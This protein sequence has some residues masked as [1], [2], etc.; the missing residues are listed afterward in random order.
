MENL[1]EYIKYIKDNI[2]SLEDSEKRM[3]NEYIFDLSSKNNIN[4]K[5]NLNALHKHLFFERK[6]NIYDYSAW[7]RRR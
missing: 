5:E 6:I 7:M 1:Q 2:E 4:I 3:I